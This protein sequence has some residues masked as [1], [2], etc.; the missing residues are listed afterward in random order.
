[1]YFDYNKAIKDVFNHKHL[2]DV[3]GDRVWF[4]RLHGKRKET[5]VAGTLEMRDEWFGKEVPKCLKSLSK[6][7]KA[8]L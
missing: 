5:I 4:R 2:E 7:K 8:S 1:M 3:L 6:T